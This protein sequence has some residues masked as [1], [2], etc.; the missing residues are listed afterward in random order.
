MADLKEHLYPL[1]E[2]CVCYLV[3]PSANGDEVLLGRKKFGLG[4]GNLVGPGGKIESGETPLDAIVREVQE[5]TSIVISKPRLAGELTYFFASKPSWSQKSWVFT[6]RD[7]VG[8]AAETDE[9]APQW[10]GV[11]IIPVDR[12]WDDAKY[13]LPLAL[14]NERAFASAGEQ[15]AQQRVIATFEFASDLRTVCASDHAA[16]ASMT[17]QQ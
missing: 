12:M 2:V 10:F 6:C 9:L 7:F 15:P 5:E 16:F 14:V 11:S 1:P 3:R 13:W 4:A 17:P 8:D